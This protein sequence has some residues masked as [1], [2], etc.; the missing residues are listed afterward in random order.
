MKKALVLSLLAVLLGSAIAWAGVT[1]SWSSFGGDFAPF[2]VGV[3]Y[4]GQY[5]VGFGA[6]ATYVDL[7]E[8]GMPYGRW[9]LEGFGTLDLTDVLYVQAGFMPIFDFTDLSPGTKVEITYCGTVGIGLGQYGS[10]LFAKVIY[11]L[12]G[13]DAVLLQIGAKIDTHGIATL[14]GEKI[15]E[16]DNSGGGE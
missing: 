14:I 3:Q 16:A 13:S 9:V 2:G 12:D 8:P 1:V 10:S 6:E 4:D 5:G 7:F 15:A 11:A